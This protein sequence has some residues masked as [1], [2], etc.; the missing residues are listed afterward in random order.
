MDFPKIDGG[1]DGGHDHRQG[2]PSND[3]GL[4]EGGALLVIMSILGPR[5]THDYRELNL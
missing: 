3:V 4:C 2:A 5:E 1:G